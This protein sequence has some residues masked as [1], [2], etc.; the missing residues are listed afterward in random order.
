ME[1]HERRRAG[2]GRFARIF[3]VENAFE[4]ELAG[5]EARDPLDV[6]PIQ[7]RVELAVGPA[8][9][10]RNVLH[11]ANVAGEIAERAPLA[12]RDAEKPGGFGRHVDDIVEAPFR[13]NRHAVLEIAM[14]LTENLQ[15]DREHERAAFGR[16][17]PL[18]QRTDKSAILHDVELKPERLVDGGGHILDRT[19]RHGRQ[20]EGNACGLRRPAGENFAVAMLH[21]A[22]PDRRQDERQRRRLAQ[23][24]G[25]GATMGNVGQNPLPQLDRFKIGAVG[26][27]RLLRIRAG[28]GIVEKLAR[29]PAACGLPQILDAGHDFHGVSPVS[30]TPDSIK[31]ARNI[32]SHA[33]VARTSK[34]H[35]DDPMSGQK[36]MSARATKKKSE[37]K[38]RGGN[39][40]P[41][42]KRHA[43]LDDQLEQGLEESFPAPIRSPSRSRPTALTTRASLKAQAG[44]CP[45]GLGR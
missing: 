29:N 18:D 10:R 17:R 39:T 35:R 20:R 14:A 26:A 40:E 28:F 9:Q 16:S 8:R 21:A 32:A 6:L 23:N 15:I 5:P 3:D 41:T 44:T 34:H 31:S 42:P 12:A 4:N 38:H 11:A 33:R 30:C 22:H 13:R 7:G 1:T 43:T 2:L 45:K 37:T 24:G 25:R 27:Q 19:D 36:S